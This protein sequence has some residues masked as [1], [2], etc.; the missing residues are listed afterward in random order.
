M[1]EVEKQES[2]KTVVAFITG[3]LIGGL[4]VWVFSSPTTQEKNDSMKT[5]EQKSEMSE[6]K[7]EK[8]EE[9][10]ADKKEGEMK[11]VMGSGK[12][13]VSDQKA[14]SK[15]TLGALEFPAQT[16]WVAV[17]DFQ[18]DTLGNVFGASFYNTDMNVVPTEIE[19][20]RNTIAGQKYAVVFFSNEGDAAFS[21]TQDKM[22]EGVMATFTA[23]E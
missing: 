20:V 12:I 11:A 6:K 18:G 8:K 5:D 19:A 7:D 4:L 9:M 17:R 13:E 16:G 15:I 14:G 23:T 1:S 22:V 10:K 2:H 3:L 21:S